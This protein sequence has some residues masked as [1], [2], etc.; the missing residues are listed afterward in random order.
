ML[1]YVPLTN[2]QVLQLIQMY[3]NDEAT[4]RHIKEVWK[5]V[6]GYDVV[7]RKPPYAHV[8]ATLNLGREIDFPPSNA[9]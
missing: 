4:Q 3:T 8:N 5:G 6:T 9:A 2:D 1:D 7:D